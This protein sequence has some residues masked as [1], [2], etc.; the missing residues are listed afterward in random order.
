[1]KCLGAIVGDFVGSKYEFHNVKVRDFSWN[2]EQHYLTDDSYMTL[3]VMDFLTNHKGDISFY[4]R[5][6]GRIHPWAG[7]GGRFQEGLFNPCMGPYN[8]FGNGSAMRVSPVGWIA[9]SEEEIIQLS[10]QVTE[11]THNHPLGIEGAEVVAMCIYYAR[12]GKTKDFIRKYARKHYEIDFS[13]DDLVKHYTFDETCRGSIPQAI[14]C[15]L[16]SNDF[17]DCLRT[18]ISIGG[19]SDTIAAIACSIAEAFYQSI[20]DDIVKAVYSK[21]STEEINLINDFN[22]KV[23][24]KNER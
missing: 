15:F 12:T 22:R 24:S 5:K 20:P 3:A 19:D 14:Y 17:E 21:L 1:M 13:Y 11:C 6:W 9:N 18:A 2:T 4:L 7:Y 10:K 16:I 8:S 23:E